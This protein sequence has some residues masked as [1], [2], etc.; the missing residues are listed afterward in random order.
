MAKKKNAEGTDSN[1]GS[2]R[3]WEFYAVRYAM[4]TVVGAIVVFFLCKETPLSPLLLAADVKTLS[5]IDLSNVQLAL[6][7]TYGLVYCYIA[8]APVLVLHA[9]RFR[10]AKGVE[11]HNIWPIAAVVLIVSAVVVYVAVPTSLSTTEKLR[12][13]VV[14]SLVLTLF[15]IECA[16]V[17]SALYRRSDLYNFYAT[18]AGKREKAKGGI[19][20]SYR[21]LREHGNSFFIVLL[22]ILL[23]LFLVGINS[24]AGEPGITLTAYLLILVLWVL[25]AVLVWAIGIAVELEF[26]GVVRSSK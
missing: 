19:T 17:I 21:H 2:T 13:R 23:G 8:S 26:A 11:T 20:D 6:L 24:L 16:M 10:F 4:G 5:P 1:E 9:G 7:A 25:P 15:L 22:E 3:W 14:G 12:Y 18:L